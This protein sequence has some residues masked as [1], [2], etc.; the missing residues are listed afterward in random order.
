LLQ[1]IK[2]SA[3]KSVLRYLSQ[4]VHFLTVKGEKDQDLRSILLLIRLQLSHISIVDE[5]PQVVREKQGPK[6]LNISIQSFVFLHQRE[7]AVCTSHRLIQ[8]VEKS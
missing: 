5:L 6:V 4:S 7:E 3:K 1:D 8:R 2:L